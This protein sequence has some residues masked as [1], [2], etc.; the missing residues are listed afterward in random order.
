[1]V[2]VVCPYRVEAHICQ[3]LQIISGQVGGYTGMDP[4][5]WNN[6]VWHLGSFVSKAGKWLCG[7]CSVSGDLT[8]AKPKYTVFTYVQWQLDLSP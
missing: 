1:V 2:K 4:R 5:I 3:G 8:L 6:T 7:L